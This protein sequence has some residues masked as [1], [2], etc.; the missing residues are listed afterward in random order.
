MRV[1]F[2]GYRGMVGSVLIERMLAENDFSKIAAYFFS[3]SAAGN[4][5]PY[6]FATNELLLDAY[7]ID[8]LMHM[9]CIVTTQGSDYTLRVYTQLQQNGYQGYFID[10][11]SALRMHDSAVIA[12]D[13]VNRDVI[14]RA[15]ANG[16]K[17]FVGGNCSITL[18]MIGL[19]GLLHSGLVDWMSMMTYQAAS[20]AGAKNVR[21]L[22]RQMQCISHENATQINNEDYPILDL[23]ASVDATIKNPSYPINEFAAPLAGSVIPWID[24][25]NGDG[26]SKEELKAE[27]EAN[28][29]L[30]L[31]PRTI[32]IDGL[33]VRV[34]VI[35]SHSCAITLRLKEALHVAK[36]KELIC[37][38]NLWI[39]YIDNNKP[40]SLKYLNPVATTNS[41]KIAVG[42]LKQSAIDDKTYHVFTVGD[43][44]LWG[45]AEPLRRMLGIII[46]Y[47]ANK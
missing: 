29:I 43:Q 28:K 9:D 20:G 12:L 33:C 46:D 37:Q 24:A 30:G 13:P 31:A 1:G 47:S 44:L 35:R 8:Q 2:I 23:I 14:D 4:K 25:D 3:T 26:S 40:D 7:D 45:A 18:S 38:N 11:S 36:V 34:G 39:D 41:L 32:K 16:I 5:S 22:L 15:L 27:R 21:Q 6:S 42:R 10:A 19:N 17:T